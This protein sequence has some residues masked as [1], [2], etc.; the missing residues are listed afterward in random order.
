[1]ILRVTRIVDLNHR[2]DGHIG[3]EQ[4]YY[5]FLSYAE[6]MIRSDVVLAQKLMVL[7]LEETI[8]DTTALQHALPTRGFKKPAAVAPRHVKVNP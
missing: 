4:G 1:V 3:H 5:I 7:R 2:L 6:H 8:A